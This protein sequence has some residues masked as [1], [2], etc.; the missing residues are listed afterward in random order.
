MKKIFLYLSSTISYIFFSQVY[1]TMADPSE[2]WN[3][4]GSELYN[5][6]KY[7]EAIKCFDKA[8]EVEPK[9]FNIFT[10]KCN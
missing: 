1:L 3:K 8:L 5:Q 10:N 4:K 7:E 6:G 9:A 2:E